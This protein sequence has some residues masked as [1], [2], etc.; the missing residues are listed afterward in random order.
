[1]LSREPLRT[2][3]IDNLYKSKNLEG[4]KKELESVERV[5]KS[6]ETD[7]ILALSDLH[8][9]EMKKALKHEKK[10]KEKIQQYIIE[11]ENELSENSKI[12]W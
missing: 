12:I 8:K 6:Y 7:L 3:Y 4:L 5:I 11:L 2:I 9:E 1:M 10:V